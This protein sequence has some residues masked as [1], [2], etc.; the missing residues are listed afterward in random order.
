VVQGS[1]R[2]G[3]WSVSSLLSLTLPYAFSRTLMIACVSP[4]EADAPETL[5]TLNYANRAKN[6]KNRVVANQD[7][8]SRMIAGLRARIAELEAEVS[9][10]KQVRLDKGNHSNS[11]DLGQSGGGTVQH[12]PARRPAQG[13]GERS[14]RGV[15][16]GR[17]FL[18]QHC[19]SS[20]TLF[21]CPPTRD[22]SKRGDT[23][24]RTTSCLIGSISISHSRSTEPSE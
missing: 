3:G 24:R 12:G 9:T 23:N 16:S 10:Y 18:N 5:N 7:K 15:Y 14:A 1:A 19:R 21:P 11:N 17:N 22:W 4:N 13:A 2:Y 6:I 8:S 20:S